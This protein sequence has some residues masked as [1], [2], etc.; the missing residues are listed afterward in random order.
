M[1]YQQFESEYSL[2][3]ILCAHRFLIPA[4]HKKVGHDGP[5]SATTFTDDSLG[6]G[7]GGGDS[8]P[9]LCADW[10]QTASDCLG[11]QSDPGLC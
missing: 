7:G 5:A 1:F 2:V 9:T 4:K 10:I 11:V 3:R 6:G 8:G